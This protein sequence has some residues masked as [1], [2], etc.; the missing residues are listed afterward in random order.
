MYQNHTKTINCVSKPHKSEEFCIEND[1]F[2]SWNLA[3]LQVAVG[4]P[5]TVWSGTW[6]YNV[7]IDGNGNTNS[8]HAD[9][10]LAASSQQPPAA[11]EV[12]ST[13][14][15]QTSARGNAQTN[16]EITATITGTT[17][18]SAA[19]LV[20]TGTGARQT[21]TFPMNHAEI[22]DLVSVTI[23]LTGNDGVQ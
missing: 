21:I 19:T 4:A 6:S 8:P 2:C 23:A 11:G 5:S 18:A 14:I 9:M 17:G 12:V 7:F 10:F 1:E 15:L 3:T 22:G 16:G 13:L 20:A